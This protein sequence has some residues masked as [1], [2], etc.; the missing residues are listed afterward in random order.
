MFYY[1]YVISEDPTYAVYTIAVLDKISL[2]PNPVMAELSVQS[3]AIKLEDLSVEVIDY[4][5]RV[6]P[7]FITLRGVDK[8]TVDVTA[9]PVGIFFLKLMSDGK[10]VKVV[11]FVKVG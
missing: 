1:R 9:L 8:L 7:S 10:L 11:R 5:G 2:S 4:V 3:D 6:Q